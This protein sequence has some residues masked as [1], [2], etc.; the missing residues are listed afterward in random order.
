MK[1]TDLYS[2]LRQIVIEWDTNPVNRLNTFF[3]ATSEEDYLS[4]DLQKTDKDYEDGYFWS[5]SY[6]YAGGIMGNIKKEDVALS[7]FHNV[8]LLPHL[9]S[10]TAEYNVAVSIQKLTAP[11][12]GKKISTVTAGLVAESMLRAVVK[13]LNSYRVYDLV[14]DPN[15]LPAG[16]YWF[17][18]GKAQYLQA[19]GT[20]INETYERFITHLSNKPA[21]IFLE[22]RLSNQELVTWTAEFFINDCEQD[23]YTFNYAP[24]P[25]VIRKGI[26]SCITC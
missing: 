21:R 9:Y 4:T 17:S 20:I 2:I 1:L 11:S 22:N 15:G 25:N 7:V 6:N 12:R 23:T 10:D 3:V 8:Q 13:E 26:T 18:V 14:N 5:R 24:Q 19:N 16:T